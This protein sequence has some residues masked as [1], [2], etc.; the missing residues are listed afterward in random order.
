MSV[1]SLVLE[2]QTRA[3]QEGDY[4]LAGLLCRNL[5]GLLRDDPAHSVDLVTVREKFKENQKLLESRAG[6]IQRQL[7]RTLGDHTS[8]RS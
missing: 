2:L 8:I 1:I 7:S 5:L 3:I 6:E 4:L